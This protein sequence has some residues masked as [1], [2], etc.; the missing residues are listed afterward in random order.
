MKQSADLQGFIRGEWNWSISCRC[1]SETQ[2]RGLQ[3]VIKIH[4]N[5]GG[6]SLRSPGPPET[7]ALGARLGNRSIFI[8]D[9]RLHMLGQHHSALTKNS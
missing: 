2:E 4:K 7:G 6:A 8:L 1:D 3:R 9:P 5:I